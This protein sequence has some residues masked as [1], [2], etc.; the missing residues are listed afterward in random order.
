M[1]NTFL[2]KA[3]LALSITIGITACNEPAKEVEKET[4][5]K[6]IL[7]WGPENIKKIINKIN[8]L[9]IQIKKNSYNPINIIL[10]FMFEQSSSK[11]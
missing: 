5:K 2:N 10:D 7:N 4:V 8:Q 3:L 11:N 1:K 6:Q 9:E